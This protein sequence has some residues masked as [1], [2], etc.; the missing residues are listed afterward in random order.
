M[1]KAEDEMNVNDF[2]FD[3][4]TTEKSIYAKRTADYTIDFWLQIR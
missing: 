2:K 1:A 4:K 3:S